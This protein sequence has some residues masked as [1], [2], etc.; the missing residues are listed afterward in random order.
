QQSKEELLT[1]LHPASGSKIGLLIGGTSSVCYFSKEFI[2]SLFDKL[3]TVCEEEQASILLTTSRRTPVEIE[4]WVQ[5][6]VCKQPYLLYALYASSDSYNPVPGILAYCDVIMVTED[7]YSMISEAASVEKPVLVLR[8]YHKKHKL[9]KYER[10]LEEMDR[11]GF[12]KRI[13]LSESEMILREV[14]SNPGSFSAQASTDTQ[15]A[16]RVLRELLF[17]NNREWTVTK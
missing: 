17:N 16:T 9:L 1:K 13:D 15:R 8:L 7:S 10:S 3:K 6:K 2:Y 11:L 14:L 4:K 5:E 12:I